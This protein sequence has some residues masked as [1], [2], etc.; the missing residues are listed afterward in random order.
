MRRHEPGQSP[1]PLDPE[2]A[3]YWRARRMLRALRGWY[4]HLIVYVGVNA[5]L[6]LKYLYL[7]APAWSHH[8]LAGWPWPL[9]TTLAW[10]LAL[11]LHGILVWTRLSPWGRDWE[12]RKIREFMDRQ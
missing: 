1:F 4:I 3:A 9:N 7:P 6:W 11:A 10:G 8:A 5:F 12:S 2:A